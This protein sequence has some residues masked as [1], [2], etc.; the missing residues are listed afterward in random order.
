[1]P[2]LHASASFFT[3]LDFKWFVETSLKQMPGVDRAEVSGGAAA[4]RVRCRMALC[5]A[6]CDR[7]ALAPDQ[8]DALSPSSVRPATRVSSAAVH[9]V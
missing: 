2:T 4:P 1:M 5:G 6:S 3:A 9:A 8:S 7:L